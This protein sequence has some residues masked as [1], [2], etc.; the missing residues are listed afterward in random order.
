MKMN[1][2]RDWKS[3]RQ[4]HSIQWRFLTWKTRRDSSRVTR[5]SSHYSR[6][7]IND[8][9]SQWH[10]NK[11]A[12][13][14]WINIH[15]I[16]QSAAMLKATFTETAHST[17]RFINPSPT[18]NR[19]NGGTNVEIAFLHTKANR[20]RGFFFFFCIQYILHAYIIYVRIKGLRERAAADRPRGA[21]V[22]PQ[23][24]CLSRTFS[25]LYSPYL[26]QN[27]PPSSSLPKLWWIKL[28]ISWQKSW[29][30]QHCCMKSIGR[31]FQDWSA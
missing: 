5:K 2:D 31:H 29:A 26:P 15:Q 30:A 7:K 4:K 18:F 25:I 8:H 16:K 1:N 24:L 12:T 6:C 14:Q 28:L 22:N 17:L 27:P 23:T 21:K 13:F 3:F 10:T 9:Y 19:D 11:L 20:P